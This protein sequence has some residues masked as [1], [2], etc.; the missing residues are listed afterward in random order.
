M[1]A[2]FLVT[3]GDHNFVFR[4]YSTGMETAVRERDL[5]QFLTSYPVKVPQ[6]FAMFETQGRPVTV[7]E[8]M[9]GMTLE[10]KLLS[11]AAI[12]LRIFEETGRQLGHIHSI[13]FSETGFIG[14]G[15]TIGNEYENFGLFIRQFIEKTLSEVPE[16]RLDTETNHRMQNLVHDQWG[17]VL[18]TEPRSQLVHSDFNPKNILVSSVANATISA[19]LDWEF[20]VSGNGLIDLGN[21]FRF[22]YD[23]PPDAQKRFEEG[24]R[25]ANNQLPEDWTDAVRL[26]DLGNM[27]S[28][29]ERKEDYQASF[30][31]ARAVIHSTLDHFGY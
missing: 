2:N 10:D 18:E 13:H 7:L 3:S 31:T 23:Y 30:R 22:S 24:Y 21:F 1:N 20:C 25:S 9:D 12:D 5:L 4:I 26:L 28:F 17:I 6:V 19:I 15:M 14:P 27:C 8:Y 29:L 11:D 16:E